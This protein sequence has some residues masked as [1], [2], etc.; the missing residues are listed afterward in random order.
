MIES[1]GLTIKLSRDDVQ[2]M[3]LTLRLNPELSQLLQSIESG[4]NV[5][6]EMAD[7]LGDCCTDRLDE[8]GFDE[9]Y[10]LSD[11]GEKLEYLID[12]LF[13]G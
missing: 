2:F 10:A 6:D 5:S 9:N 8:I 1:S 7:D 3:R 13:I 11:D 4:G 12:K